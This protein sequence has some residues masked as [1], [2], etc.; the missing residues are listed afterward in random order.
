MSYKGQS[1]RFLRV[2]ATYAYPPKLAVKA[3]VPDW[4][5]QAI[6]RVS[7]PSVK[8]IFGLLARRRHPCC[9]FSPGDF[10]TVPLAALT[11]RHQFAPA[12]EMS[13][14]AGHGPPCEA[15][16][17]ISAF[18]SGCSRCLFQHPLFWPQR[19]VAGGKNN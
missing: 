5:R 17:A 2:Q 14:M 7:G 15:S 12:F 3:D 10:G 4:L 8:P 19:M 18:G 9:P 13:V 11:S 6:D 1:R 16:L